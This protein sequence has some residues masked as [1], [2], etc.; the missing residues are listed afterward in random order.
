MAH[1]CDHA[2]APLP[3]PPL[4]TCRIRHPALF[5]ELKIY[6]LSTAYIYIYISGSACL[7]CKSTVP[8][9]LQ[10]GSLL[11]TFPNCRFNYLRPTSVILRLYN[12]STKRV[13]KSFRNNNGVS[14]KAIFCTELLSSATDSNL[15][16][17]V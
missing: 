12:S 14:L 5:R 7:P 3:L 17:T 13:C 6:K 16:L 1:Q 15:K 9:H 2:N 8:A 11:S 10:T 4:I